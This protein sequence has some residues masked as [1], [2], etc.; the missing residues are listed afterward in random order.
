[1]A[2]HWGPT[3]KKTLNLQHQSSA[4]LTREDFIQSNN[5]PVIPYCCNLNKSRRCKV[6]FPATALSVDWYWDG[7]GPW[8]GIPF[9]YVCSMPP[10]QLSL[11]TG[12]GWEMR[13]GQ[14]VVIHC[15]W[16][17]RQDGSFHSWI[18]VRVAG[19]TVK[20]WHRLKT[21]IQINVF[22]K[23]KF[24]SL[25]WCTFPCCSALSPKNS[26][27]V[28][29]AFSVFYVEVIKLTFMWYNICSAAYILQVILCN[30]Q[31]SLLSQQRWI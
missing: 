8:A 22:L 17:Q 26:S 1:V 20:C 10:I 11:L 12:V 29:S 23:H 18:N 13:I 2:L 27:A 5:G 30:I 9:L 6:W 16:D 24:F 15:S 31:R 7:H 19:N 25:H 14:S 4:F 3:P 21:H 28:C